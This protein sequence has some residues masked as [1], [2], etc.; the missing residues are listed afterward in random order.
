MRRLRFSIAGLMG[1]VVV[2]AVGLAALQN[3]TS[4]WAGAIF[5]ITYGWLG[6][7]IVG[8]IYRRGAAR[9]WWLGFAVFGCGYLVMMSSSDGRLPFPATPTAEVLGR[10]RTVF[11][12]PAAAMGPQAGTIMPTLYLYTQ[13]GHALWALVIGLLGGL[14][15][16]VFRSLPA[17]PDEAPAAEAPASPASPPRRWVRPAFVAWVGSLLACSAAAVRYGPDAR[18]WAGA[19]FFLTW[20]LLGMAG[21]VAIF[22]RGRRRQMAVGAVLLGVGYLLLAFGRAS[23]QIGPVGSQVVAVRSLYQP[24]PTTSFLNGVRRWASGYARGDLAANARIVAALEQ[25]VAMTFPDPTPLEDVLRYVQMATSTPTYRGIPIFLDPAGLQAAEKTPRSPVT[26]DLVDVPL[27]TSLRLCLKPMGLDYEVRDGY[28]WVRADEE[29]L[30][31]P[32]D[33]DEIARRSRWIAPAL[34]EDSSDIDDPLLVVGH[35][36]LAL[37]AAGVGAVAAPIAAGTRAGSGRPESA[38]R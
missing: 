27:R 1:V 8:A 26:I 29:N 24:L 14:L 12:H 4:A 35:C 6:V 19:A 22:G 25:R 3:P 30:S 17:G 32:D 37:L 23:Y 13:I 38:G 2:A 28:L 11:G 5:M 15:A 18:A 10:L 16:G 33:L 36:L 34:V 20:G 7:A 9:A 21:L 31:E